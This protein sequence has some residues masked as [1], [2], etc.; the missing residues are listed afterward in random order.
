M[1]GC[2]GLNCVPGMP[3]PASTSISAA[4]KRVHSSLVNASN[5]LVSVR[6]LCLAVLVLYLRGDS[7]QEVIVRQHFDLRSCRLSNH[8]TKMRKSDKIHATMVQWV[9]TA[10]HR[11]RKL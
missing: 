5:K 7:L 1:R 9:F 8:D 3:P 10:D 6:T 2:S 11:A 4:L